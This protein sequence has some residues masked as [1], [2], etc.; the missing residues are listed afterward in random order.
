MTEEKLYNECDVCGDTAILE[1]HPVTGE[2][3][4]AP[5]HA[6]ET[7]FQE[8]EQRRADAFIDTLEIF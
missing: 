8:D 1:P 3:L 4:C 6:E 2:L 7:A 5:C